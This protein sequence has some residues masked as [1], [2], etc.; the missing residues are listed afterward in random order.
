MLGGQTPP[1]CTFSTLIVLVLSQSCPNAPIPVGQ[2]PQMG[3]SMMGRSIAAG[4]VMMVSFMN[5]SLPRLI[6]MVSFIIL[7]LKNKFI[8]MKSVPLILGSYVPIHFVCVCCSDRLW[9]TSR[10]FKWPCWADLHY[11]RQCGYLQLWWRVHA[12]WSSHKD[13]HVHWKL[14]K[15][16]ACLCL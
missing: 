10:P 13:L 7:T 16:R 3:L 1:R 2:V 8:R 4:V 6:V 9:Y 5:T 14:V 15:H 12:I 11:W